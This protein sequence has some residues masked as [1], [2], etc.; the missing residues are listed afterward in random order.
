MDITSEEEILL[1]TK[2]SIYVFPYLKQTPQ[3]NFHGVGG[4]QPNLEAK[5]A[6]EQPALLLGSGKL[7]FAAGLARTLLATAFPLW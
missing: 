5:P 4:E 2:I 1:H 6:S 3:G 7:M